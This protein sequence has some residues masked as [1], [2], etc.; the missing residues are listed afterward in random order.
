MMLVKVRQE[1]ISLVLHEAVKY[2]EV[3]VITTLIDAGSDPNAVTNTGRTP[4]HVAC[5]NGKYASAEVLLQHG[6]DI[7]KK[8]NDGTNAIDYAKQNNHPSIVQL[9]EQQ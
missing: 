4:L 1:K 8:S 7:W 2:D 3:N 9:L 6:A 5:L